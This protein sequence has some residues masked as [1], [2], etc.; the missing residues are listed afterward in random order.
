MALT[1]DS[2]LAGKHKSLLVTSPCPQDGK[3]LVAVNLA[4]AFAAFL[5]RPTLLVDADLRRPRVLRWL[6]KPPD[7]GLLERLLPETEDAGL[8]GIQGL[9]LYVLPSTR[10]C[11]TAPAVLA[12][13]PFAELMS[14][15][16]K[17]FHCV[18]VDTPPLVA[19]ADAAVVERYT[20]GTVMVVREGHTPHALADQAFG[21]LAHDRFVLVALN[22]A[23]P[24]L[25]DGR[26]A[27]GR[28]YRYYQKGSESS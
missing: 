13:P 23:N 9:P 11:P 19:F 15:M 18:I 10:A 16:R 2:G 8:A 3:S 21:S 4:A 28:Y 27:S 26:G 24:N 25:I 12:S 5:G 20:E 6:R 7:S 17:A 1:I 22:A 14:A